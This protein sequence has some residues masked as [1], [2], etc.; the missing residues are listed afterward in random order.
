MNPF[1]RCAGAWAGLLLMVFV[2]S[3]CG[4]SDPGSKLVGSWVQHFETGSGEYDSAMTSG[5]EKAAPRFQFTDLQNFTFARGSAQPSSGQ[6][7]VV[8]V[9]R[10]DGNRIVI[11]MSITAEPGAAPQEL[12]FSVE[13]DGDD[14][15]R[16]QPMDKTEKPQTYVR[17]RASGAMTKHERRNL[18][19]E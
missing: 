6:W 18:K 19:P 1:T 10:D 8:R 15:F 12:E 5:S 16:L 2:M 3:G 7:R 9:I 4:D 14:R 17:V 11:S 13:F